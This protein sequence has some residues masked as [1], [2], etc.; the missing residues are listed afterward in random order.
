MNSPISG[1]ESR[2]LD[3]LVTRARSELGAG[4]E[5]LSEEGERCDPL[6]LIERSMGAM[7]GH[8]V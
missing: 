1:F 8:S 2:V 3:D 4:Y 5:S 6:E 7:Q